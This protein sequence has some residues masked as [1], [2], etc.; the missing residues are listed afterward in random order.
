MPRVT[1]VP[2]IIPVPR[3]T[4]AAPLP[5][6][7]VLAALALTVLPACNGLNERQ[8]AWLS[9]GERAYHG[10]QYGVAVQKLSSFL[11]EVPQGPD[12][13]RAAYVRGQA[14]ALLGQR[15]AAYAD[16]QRAAETGDTDVAWRAA[17]ALGVLHF[18]DEHWAAAAQNL[19]RAVDR[20]PKQPPMDALLFRLA[21]SLERAGRW[22]D[23]LAAHRRIASEFP[24]STYAA[25]ANRRLQARPTYF[26]VQA[27]A[28][29]QAASAERLAADL[30]QG[31]LDAHV[32]P[33]AR[34]GGALYLVLVGRAAS[35]DAAKA[36]HNQVRGHVPDA[37]I[38]P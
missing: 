18:E 37:V 16:L 6:A 36:L 9:E 13:A 17:A 15:Q 3:V 1:P 34:D 19:Q 10:K 24:S 25:R 4:L 35:Y 7:L 20:M 8:R 22:S 27:G 32:R 31:G 5:A 14:R 29:S 2:R 23:G 26:A 30:R 38:W 28:F 21:V 12:A 33:E 11:S